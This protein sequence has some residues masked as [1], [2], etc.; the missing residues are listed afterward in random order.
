MRRSWLQWVISSILL[1]APFVGDAVAAQRLDRPRLP[2]TPFSYGPPALPPALAALDS[3][4]SGNPVTDAGATLGRVLFHD[5]RLSVNGLVAC[6][7]CHAQ[8]AGFDDPTRFSIGF[9]GR[10]TRRSAMA[11]ANARLNPGGRHFRDERAQ[12]LEAQVLMPFTDPVEMGLKPGEPVARVAAR[13]WYGP[14]FAAAFG[15]P[16]VDEARI[17]AALA[18]FVRALVSLDAP[19]DRARREVAAA[20]DDF[21]AFSA[22]Q[23]RGKFLFMTAREKSGA[24]CAAC[25]ETDAFVM[26]EP[27][28]N[29]LPPLDGRPDGGI[30]EI[31]SRQED[32]GRFRAPSLRNVAVSAPYMRDGRFRSLGDVLDHY[33]S[34][35]APNANL[36]AQLRAPDGSPARLDLPPADRAALVA[37]IETL[38]DTQ[39]LADPRF[40]DPFLVPAGN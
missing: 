24:G 19:Y 10:I 6:S 7:S 9:D 27:R 21:P 14:L 39:F 3:T 26:L 18:Q 2:A 37:F 15:D 20:T 23:N 1:C 28:D 31:T 17:A 35:V 40:A 34:G 12:T 38:T 13:D 8:A 29:G 16:H 33:A 5:R 36:A 11:L 22:E 30:G 4:P 32:M 25:H